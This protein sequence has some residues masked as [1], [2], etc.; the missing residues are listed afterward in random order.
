MFEGLK[1]K[2]SSFVDSLSKKES[3]PGQITEGQESN[4]VSEAPVT[5]HSQTVGKQEATGQPELKI[6]SDMQPGAET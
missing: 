3:G 6:D 4:Q 1:K 5:A 2:F